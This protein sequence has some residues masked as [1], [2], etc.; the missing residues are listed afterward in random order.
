MTGLKEADGNFFG[1][2]F[3][4]SKPDADHAGGNAAR[5]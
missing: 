1:V 5:A 4:V 3:S 2:G